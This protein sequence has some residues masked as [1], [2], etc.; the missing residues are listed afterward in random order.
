VVSILLG[1]SVF[2][3]FLLV[4]AICLG[5]MFYYKKKLK[6]I[7]HLDHEGVVERNLRL[8]TYKELIEATNGFK[9]EL[10]RGSCGI[11]YKGEVETARVA[12]KKLDR[13]FEDSDKEFKTEV[14]VIG[15]THH[16][17]LVRLLGYCA[18]GQHRTYASV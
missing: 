4:G 11:V 2:V 18:E 15:K 3:N 7:S 5:F 14:N 10:G 1:S 6:R 9:E 13:L 16:K 12:V 17:N 8:F